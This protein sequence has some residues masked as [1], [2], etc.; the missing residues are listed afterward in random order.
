MIYRIFHTLWFFFQ[1]L[2]LKSQYRPIGWKI[3]QTEQVY[4]PIQ[5]PGTI[6]TVL[7]H[8][9][10]FRP[11]SLF[12][13]FPVGS[14]LYNIKMKTLKVHCGCCKTFPIPTIWENQKKAKAGVGEA[15]Q[16]PLSIFEVELKFDRNYTKKQKSSAWV[17]SNKSGVRTCGALA[18][19]IGNKMTCKKKLELV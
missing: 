16:H 14:G 11:Q 17:L 18:W 4:S 3:N 1:E 12:Q 7:D 19:A 8:T 13:P 6:S 2:S 10:F 15:L 5:Q 9:C